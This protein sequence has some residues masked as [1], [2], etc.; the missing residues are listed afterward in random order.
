MRA[1]WGSFIAGMDGGLDDGTRPGEVREGSAVGL[2]VRRAERCAVGVVG[3]AQPR[4]GRRPRIHRAHPD[5]VHHLAIVG[6]ALRVDHR[7]R[8]AIDERPGSRALEA[9]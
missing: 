5:T 4:A 8:Y 9:L 2:E 7:P 1:W 6:E 3:D